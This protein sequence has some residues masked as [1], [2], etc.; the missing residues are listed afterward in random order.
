MDGATS[1]GRAPALL[2]YVGVPAPLS[3]Q[4]RSLPHFVQPTCAYPISMTSWHVSE[5]VDEHRHDDR[6]S[7]GIPK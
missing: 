4:Q 5:H 2:K 3:T 7:H 6:T 1:R